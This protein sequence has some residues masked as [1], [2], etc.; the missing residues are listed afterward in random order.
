M[1]M[2]II[3]PTVQAITQQ[4]KT[5]IITETSNGLLLSRHCSELFSLQWIS[6]KQ[7]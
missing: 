2:Y 4:S 5:Q 1:Y 6:A 7:K 3:R